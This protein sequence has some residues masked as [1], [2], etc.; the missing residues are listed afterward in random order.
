MTTN[1]AATGYALARQVFGRSLLTIDDLNKDSSEYLKGF[2]EE[3]LEELRQTP[4]PLELIEL[5]RGFMLRPSD[6]SKIPQL[7]TPFRAVPHVMNW[8]GTRHVCWVLMRVWQNGVLP[9]C[10]AFI[11]PKDGGDV[12]VI[13][14]FKKP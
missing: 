6:A 2:T 10:L 5:Y 3:E 7:L 12:V 11:T 14:V 9:T 4:P 13:P 8:K 1:T